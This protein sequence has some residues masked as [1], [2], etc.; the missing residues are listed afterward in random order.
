MSKWGGGGEGAAAHVVR[1]DTASYAITDE[2]DGAKAT[3]AGVH[4]DGEPSASC[5]L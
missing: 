1:T 5:L 4:A 2:G 3:L